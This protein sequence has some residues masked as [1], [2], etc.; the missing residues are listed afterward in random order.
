[1]SVEISVTTLDDDL[2]RAMEPRA[3]AP[4]RRLDAIETLA[5]AGVPVTVLTAP[6][7]PGLNDHE[8]P[9]ILAEAARRGATNAS[10]TVLRLPFVVKD[11][12]T[13]WLEEVV[14]DR[15]D[16][17][18]NRI[19]EMRDGKLNTAAFGERMK[20]KGVFADQIRALFEVACRRAGLTRGWPEL[21]VEN[22]RRPEAPRAQLSLF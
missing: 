15:K 2:A 3:S 10:Y 22:F 14:P 17:V 20:A 6:V 8:I 19:R 13:K 18:L 5:R 9:A 12:F 4:R 11:L 7:I 1:V 21:T 16:K